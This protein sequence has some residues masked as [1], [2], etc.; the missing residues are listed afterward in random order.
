MLRKNS[1]KNKIY[2]KYKIIIQSKEEKHNFR[3][4]ETKI[5]TLK[6]SKKY[7][8]AGGKDLSGEY[9]NNLTK[10]W[11]DI[12]GKKYGHKRISKLLEKYHKVSQNSSVNIL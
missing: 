10:D 5:L 3:H 8:S 12:F 9:E 11:Q 4:I 7:Y 2:I 6:S 1:L